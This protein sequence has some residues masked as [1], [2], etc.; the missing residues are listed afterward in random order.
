[1]NIN[2][3]KETQVLRVIEALTLIGDRETAGWIFKQYQEQK[4]GGP[5]K[6]RL[7]QQGFVI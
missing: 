5:W 2:S 4:K 1:M 3:L 7:R 6:A